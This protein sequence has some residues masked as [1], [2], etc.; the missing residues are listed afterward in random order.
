MDNVG[1]KY[2]SAN[3]LLYPIVDFLL[4]QHEL[5][6]MPA[7]VLPFDYNCAPILLCCDAIINSVRLEYDVKLPQMAAR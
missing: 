6:S 7:P 2:P 4:I 3:A 1:K 5:L